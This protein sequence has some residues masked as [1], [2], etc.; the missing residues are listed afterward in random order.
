MRYC[1]KF[2]QKPTWN[3]Q[4]KREILPLEGGSCEKI[5]SWFDQASSRAQP[6]GSPRTERHISNFKHL[7]VRPELVEGRSDDF[8][9]ASGREKGGG[10]R[11]D[12]Y[13]KH[14]KETLFLPLT[15]TLSR[16]GRGEIT[17]DNTPPRAGGVNLAFRADNCFIKAF[18]TIEDK[19]E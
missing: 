10:E 18:P 2:H 6:S 11:P 1:Q 15:L 12:G 14:S 5:R 3:I 19:K 7:A 8:F 17:F 9:T 16:K 13:R 4:K